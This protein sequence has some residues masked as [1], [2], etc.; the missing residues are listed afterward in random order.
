MELKNR[1]MKE[2]LKVWIE[3]THI[4]W[5][6]GGDDLD[7]D[8]EYFKGLPNKIELTFPEPKE[9]ED[10]KFYERKVKTFLTQLYQHKIIGF[11]IRQGWDDLLPF[12]TEQKDRIE[13]LKY[14]LDEGWIT[15][16]FFRTEY[17]RIINQ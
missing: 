1:D 15:G 5:D 8:D 4:I 13:K 16:E 2:Q 9:R 14:S 7:W 6:D 11:D 12:S 17:S 3:I 10:I